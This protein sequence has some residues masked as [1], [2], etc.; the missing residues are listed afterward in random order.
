MPRVT[1]QNGGPV[2]NLVHGRGVA[3]RSRCRKDRTKHMSV[4]RTRR[5]AGK[6]D[7]NFHAALPVLLKIATAMPVAGVVAIGELAWEPC[8]NSPG[9]CW[10]SYFLKRRFWDRRYRCG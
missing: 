6:S 2:C 3:P 1:H 10:P 8:R 7:E 4:H 5:D 9:S